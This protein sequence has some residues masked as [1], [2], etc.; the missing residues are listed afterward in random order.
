[1][2][3]NKINLIA[4]IGVNHN[5]NIKTAIKMIDLAKKIECDFVKFQLFKAENLVKKKTAL[6]NYQKRNS[7]NT[8]T[9]FDMLKKLELNF[10][11]IKIIKKFCDK[12]KIKFLCTAFDLEGIKFLHEKLNT[13]FIK[14]S[15]TDL[16]NY[17]LLFYAGR[18]FKKIFLSTGLSD[19]KKVD[20]A[21]KVLVLSRKYNTFYK[22]SNHIN[23]KKRFNFSLLKNKVVIFQCTSSYPCKDSEANLNVLETYK[24]KYKLDVGFSDHTIGTEL[25]LV[26]VGFGCRY[27]EKHFTLNKKFKGPDHATSLNYKELKYLNNSL[28]KTSKA[29]GTYNKKLTASEIK[30]KKAVRKS[31]YV[32]KKILKNK[33][34]NL[35]DLV[36][37]R[38]FVKENSKKIF[39]ITG[40]K[41]A[42]NLKIGSI[43]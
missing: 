12:K 42:K 20:L 39:V 40:K 43:L 37:K 9:Q 16:D 29:L 21:L 35:D 25:A 2:K 17:P 41:S 33:I 5:G 1:M 6:A 14:I 11:D 27:I 19:I 3:N 22:C 10:N 36:F 18:K 31:Y 32:K 8:K 26:S 23:S 4:E 24:K 30:N 7:L 28:K 15:S 13:K 34:V 38:P